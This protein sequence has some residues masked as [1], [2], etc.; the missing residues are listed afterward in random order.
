VLNPFGALRRWYCTWNLIAMVILFMLLMAVQVAAG[1][2][3][4][5]FDIQGH[6]GARGLLPENAM[7][8]FLRAVD[9]GVTTLE[10][11]VVVSAD[12]VVVVSHEPWMSATI[13]SDPEG[14]A[15]IQGRDHNIFEMEYE[16]VVRYDCGSR[17]HPGFPH[18]EK[19]P[20]VKPRLSEVINLVEEDV[21]SRGTAQMRYNIELKSRV[22]WDGTYTPPPAEFVRLVYEVVV[23]ADI[24]DR[25]TIQSFDVRT[26]QAARRLGAAWR[27]AVLEG[28][29]RDMASVI[30][31][32]GFTP[33]IYS[34]NY[35]LVDASVVE[36]VHAR[37]MLIIPWTVNE[38]E[39][40]KRLVDMGVDGLIT[41]YPDRALALDAP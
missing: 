28:S 17:G 15:I 11:D 30:E 36:A 41:D 29:D 13:C 10:I 5:H 3:H 22:E 33:H 38:V 20:A 39:E 24:M 12:S 9:L 37:G 26:L 27:L 4:P 23:A 32:L 31:R 40:M 19:Q 21:A 6:R 25:V 2:P 7:A 35:R 8:G 1:Q 16:S 34:P 14:Q 18:Q